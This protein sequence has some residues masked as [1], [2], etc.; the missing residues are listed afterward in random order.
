[1][2][3][4]LESL[5]P[6][7]SVVARRRARGFP[8]L[9]PV[10]DQYTAYLHLEM[11]L[12]FLNGLDHAALVIS[13][14]LVDFA[15]KNAVYYKAY[16][17]AGCKFDPNQWDNVDG[18]EFGNVI[19]RAKTQGVVT[20]EQWQQL[21]WLREHVRNVYMHGATPE[22]LKD[23]AMSGVIVGNLDTGEVEERTVK[24]RE[25]LSL[26]RE[27][28]IRADRNA[29]NEVIP[30]VDGLVRVLARGIVLRLEDWRTKNPSTA[31]KAQVDRI[32][33]NMHKQ[34][35]EV[36]Q[37]VMRDIPPDLV[38]PDKTNGPKTEGTPG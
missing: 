33:E 14:A 22:W 5:Y 19:G 15:V 30:I 10:P 11:W 16:V 26:Q 9:D 7:E 28:R 23:K 32:L 25:N 6:D 4:I 27:A 35:L 12:C 38:P 24:L 8:R 20:K 34:G 1:M 37:I 36:D 17:D 2:N 13:C 31:I 3:P 29:C 18:L 21:E